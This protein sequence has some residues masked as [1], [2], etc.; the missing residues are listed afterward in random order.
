MTSM[1]ARTGAGVFPPRRPGQTD[2]DL[3]KELNERKAP[4]DSTIITRTE[5]DII[6][7]MI[8]G[9]S[10]MTKPLRSVS[11]SHTAVTEEHKRRMQEYDDEHRLHGGIEKSLEDI[12]NEQQRRLNLERA[13]HL[14]DEQFEE[15]RA[16]NQIMTEAK[17]IAV[18]NAQMRE[19]KRQAEEEREYERQCSEMLLAEARKAQKMYEERER[20]QLEG[21]KKNLDVIK[22]QLHEREIERIRILETHQQEQEAMTRHIERLREEEAAAKLRRQ[23]AARHLMEDAAFANAEQ[24][25]LKKRRQELELEEEKRIVEY[26][27]QKQERERL[28]AEEQQRIRDE[29]EREIAR[30][31]AQ[32]R[33]AQDKQA[34]LDNIRARRAQE[35]HARELRRKEMERKEHERAVQDDLMRARELQME[36]RRRIKEEQRQQEVEE[37]EHIIAVQKVGLEQ[38]RARKA[39]ARQQYE[40]NSL[41]VL[42]QIMEVEERRRRERQEYV[43]E[44]NH[45]MMKIRERE[46]AIEAIRQRKQKELEELGVPEEYSQAL[47]RKVKVRGMM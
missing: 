4:C 12:E 37:L 43:A 18:R 22:A 33:R 24:I 34:E 36:E 41:A 10:V 20:Q 17:C 47:M 21:Q 23:E 31:Q 45:I 46:S 6:R 16:M 9:K 30:L 15:V 40:E 2:G 8:A 38:E 11:R 26:I 13:K 44:G 3:R 19:K 7:D 1:M 5:L 35:A 14:I 32:Q 28:F 29:K 42:K 39:R 27:K 25:K